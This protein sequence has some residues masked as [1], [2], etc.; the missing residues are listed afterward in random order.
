M[1]VQEMASKFEA[2]DAEVL[3]FIFGKWIEMNWTERNA[4][5]EEIDARHN[6]KHGWF[7]I[8]G[9]SFS[10][11]DAFPDRVFVNSWD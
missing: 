1:T 5:Q 8:D 9:K 10:R 6:Y 4:K 11:E 2:Y 3:A 7:I